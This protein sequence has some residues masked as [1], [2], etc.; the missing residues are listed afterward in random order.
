MGNLYVLFSNK[1]EFDQ[2]LIFGFDKQGS[3][4]MKYEL[5]IQYPRILFI[6]VSKDNQK[7]QY[8]KNQS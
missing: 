4:W 1:N 8:N 2:L 3:V 7:I 6:K 5:V